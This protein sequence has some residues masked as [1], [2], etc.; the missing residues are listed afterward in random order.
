VLYFWEKILKNLYSNRASFTPLL[1]LFLLSIFAYFGFKAIFTAIGQDIR[2]EALIAAFGALFVLLPTKFLMEQEGESR[3]KGD[4][5]SA[6]FTANLQDYRNFATKIIDV[7]KDR[8]ITTEELSELRQQH[9]F[10]VLL[11]SNNAIEISRKFIETCQQF[12]ESS[13]QSNDDGVGLSDEQQQELWELTIH[14][15]SAARVGL[16]LAEDDFN[17]EAEKKAFNRLNDNQIEIEKIF[18]PR[19][20]LLNGFDEWCVV[21]NLEPNQKKGLKIFI[22]QIKNTNPSLKEKYTKSVISIRDTNNEKE[23]RVLYIDGINKKNHIKACFNSTEN[24][25]FFNAVKEKLGIFSVK[26]EAHREGKRQIVRIS[27]PITQNLKNQIE[28]ICISV[29]EYIK[30]QS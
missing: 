28:P 5:R 7:L 26:S 17:F 24:L 15:L 13:E 25:N 11:G 22:E 9:A 23:R 18:P 27:I 2:S 21:R 1:M 3:L 10:L 30:M 6:V 8:K 19:Q 12:M 16:Q 14:F 20:E 29:K 4:K